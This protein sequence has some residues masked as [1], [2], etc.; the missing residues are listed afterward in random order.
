MQDSYIKLLFFIS[1]VFLFS[2]TPNSYAKKL[3]KPDPPAEVRV[4]GNRIHRNTIQVIVK[5]IGRQQ[6]S[7][8]YLYI[9]IKRYHDP[10]IDSIPLWSGKSD[11][12][13]FEKIIQHNF[14]IPGEKAR[15]TAGFRFYS[16]QDSVIYGETRRQCFYSLEDTLLQAVDDY[17][18]L[19]M[20]YANYLIGKKGYKHLKYEEIEERDPKFWKEIHTILNRRYNSDG[21]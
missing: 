8:G 7:D 19:D 1:L 5:A 4:S 10:L 3:T 17:G 6:F 20:D 2:F 16:I 9:T 21:E 11:S 18:F 13:F 15:V 12:T 14:T